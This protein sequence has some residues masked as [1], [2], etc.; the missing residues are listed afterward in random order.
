[1]RAPWSWVMAACEP[2]VRNARAKFCGRNGGRARC[3]HR[4]ARVM[5]GSV[6]HGEGAGVTGPNHG[7]RA[8]RGLAARWG[9]RALPQRGTGGMAMGARQ[10]DEAARWSAAGPPGSRPAATGLDHGARTRGG[11][12]KAGMGRKRKFSLTG[13]EKFDCIEVRFTPGN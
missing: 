1:M 12:V 9:H 4:A 5:S 2:R 6:G 10:W 7:A 13:T 11:A 8:M 3:P